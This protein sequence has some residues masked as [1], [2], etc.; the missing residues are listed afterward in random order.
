VRQLGD[1]GAGRVRYVLNAPLVWAEELAVLV[2]GWMTFIGAAYA[3]RTGSHISVDTVRRLASPPVRVALDC[4][5]AL[6]IA[7]VA[8]VLIYEGAKLTVATW[9]LEYPAMGISRGWL[10]AAAPVGFALVQ[11]ELV[12]RPF[13]RDPVPEGLKTS[14][15]GDAVSS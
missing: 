11:M 1:A 2:F 15:G 12:R 6:A 14:A 4:V 10:Y 3:Q 8:I 5:C 7:V 9:S 13:S